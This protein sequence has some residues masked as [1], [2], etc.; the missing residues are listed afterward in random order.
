MGKKNIH[1]HIYLNANTVQEEEKGVGAGG[2]RLNENWI[3]LTRL[4]DVVF[5]YFD[6][7]IVK[8]VKTHSKLHIYPQPTE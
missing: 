6:V 5:V 2:C 1:I 3:L 7:A 4:N 8:D